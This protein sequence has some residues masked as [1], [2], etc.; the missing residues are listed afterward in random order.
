MSR[1][2][3]RFLPAWRRSKALLFLCAAILLPAPLIGCSSLRFE[4]AGESSIVH[5]RGEVKSVRRVQLA[6]YGTGWARFEQFI[7]DEPI[8][9]AADWRTVWREQDTNRWINRRRGPD[10]YNWTDP[11]RRLPKGPPGGLTTEVY[12]LT[13]DLPETVVRWV[14]SLDPIT[15]ATGPSDAAN[16]V[17]SQ[18]GSG[19]VE[20]I[21]AKY[22]RIRLV[23]ERAQDILV[24]RIYTQASGGEIRVIPLPGEGM[25]LGD[26]VTNVG[27]VLAPSEEA[28]VAP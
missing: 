17:H 19:F 6:R 7:V 10:F 25:K 2:K 3:A 21:V 24:T 28:D 16:K 11:M 4:G 13:P 15:V 23:Q 5:E 8:D 22:T 18:S 27:E 12:A 20:Y 14:V 26:V 9:E 1:H